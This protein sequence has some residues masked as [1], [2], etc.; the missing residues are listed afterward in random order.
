M[1][2]CVT[3]IQYLFLF[4]INIYYILESKNL[5]RFIYFLLITW[6]HRLQVFEQLIRS[7]NVVMFSKICSKISVKIISMLQKSWTNH[8]KM[9][10]LFI[11]TSCQ[12]FIT[13]IGALRIMVVFLTSVHMKLHF[14]KV[15]FQ[16][17]KENIWLFRCK[18]AVNTE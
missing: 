11:M 7:F 5:L 9:S 8:K 13:A 18:L 3:L 10:F 1:S 16:K 17:I 2:L 6:F 14:I 15:A 4:Y 12:H